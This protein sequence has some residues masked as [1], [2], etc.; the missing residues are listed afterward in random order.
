MITRTKRSAS[1]SLSERVADT[2]RERIR[3]GQY[4]DGERLPAERILTD[5]LDV[6]RRVVRAAVSRLAKEGFVFHRPN[7]RP[8]ARAP[9]AGLAPAA[10][11]SPRSAHTNETP[12][13]EV[14]SLSKFVALVMWHGGGP[15]ESSGGTSQ[16]RIFWGMNQALG[17]AGYH[18]AFLDL[19]EQIGS[20]HENA[21]REAAHLQYILDNH[22]GGVVF[23]AYAYQ[24]N[25]E[26][27]QKVAR[28][29]PMVLIDRTL[30][31]VQADFVGVNN[32]EGM[33]DAAARLLALGHRRIAYLTQS[34]S[35]N[36]VQDRLQ[37]YLQAVRGREFSGVEEIVITTPAV[38]RERWPVFEMVFRQPAG[39]RPTAALCFSDYEAVRVTRR[40]EQLGLSVPE[41]V[42]VIG[43]DDI[44]HNLPNGVGLSSVAQPFEELGRTA[45][46]LFLRR[47]KDPSAVHSHIELPTT[48]VV[49]D[50]S[51]APSE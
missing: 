21:E 18:G 34:E 25:R 30:T 7:C 48:F 40:L 11:T 26:L 8:I 9:V 37:G 28:Q 31:G 47:V 32:R 5:E 33:A 16:Q 22:F 15:L 20:L 39:E 50:S 43:F 36:A 45:A 4:A 41:D 29:V 35:I 49:R 17:Q 27:V 19:G 13:A 42:S 24:S 44:V 23:Y 3:S 12:S 46:G 10:E 6:D 2:L 14:Q 1:S 51:G 38:A